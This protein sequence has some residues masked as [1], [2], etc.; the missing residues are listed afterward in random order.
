MGE[1]ISDRRNSM[2]KGIIVMKSMESL[3]QSKKF[4]V[5]MG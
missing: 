4:S 1:A 3:I 2:N 5:F